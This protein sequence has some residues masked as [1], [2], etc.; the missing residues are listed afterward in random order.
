[1][2]YIQYTAFKIYLRNFNILVFKFYAFG[3]RGNEICVFQRQTVHFKVGIR[4]E[5]IPK[6]DTCQGDNPW[7]KSR[8][9]AI[10]IVLRLH[11]FYKGLLFCGFEAI[12]IATGRCSAKSVQVVGRGF[13]TTQ[14]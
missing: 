14:F 2:G 10:G 12:M 1:M 8:I 11:T 9:R 13:F 5:K 6:D 3:L 7:I 4:E